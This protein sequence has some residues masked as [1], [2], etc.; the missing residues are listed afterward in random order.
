MRIQWRHGEEDPTPHRE[1]G[2]TTE[3][4]DGGAFTFEVLAHA[5]NWAGGVP[6][7]S[8]VRHLECRADKRKE[9]IGGGERKRKAAAAVLRVGRRRRRAGGGLLLQPPRTRD[10]DGSEKV[11]G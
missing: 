6:S 1:K 3:P 11:C 5:G 9:K 10:R 2:T 8:C 4:V 7:Q